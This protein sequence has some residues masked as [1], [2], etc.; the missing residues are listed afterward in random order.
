MDH[1][2]QPTDSVAVAN[3]SWKVIGKATVTSKVETSCDLCDKRDSH[4][5]RQ[6]AYMTT[7]R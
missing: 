6:H 7:I 5:M 3:S 1:Q 4:C 2:L